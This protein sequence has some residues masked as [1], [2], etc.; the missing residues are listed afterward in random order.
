MKIE[1]LHQILDGEKGVKREGKGGYAVS[2]DAELTVLL[3]IGHETL[4]V[5]RVKRL[6]SQPELLTIETHK[7]ERFYLGPDTP[8]RG[9]KFA[10][11]ESNKLRGAGFMK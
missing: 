6:V 8:V 9:L 4:S 10:E 1:L 3:E 11:V 5:M 2:E 7:G